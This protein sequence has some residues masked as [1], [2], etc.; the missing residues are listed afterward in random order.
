[1]KYV[2]VLVIV[3]VAVWVMMGRSRGRGRDSKPDG[4]G[5]DDPP[6]AAG[7]AKAAGTNGSAATQTMVGCTHCGLHLPRSEAVADAQ[8]R[9][10]CGDV[11]RLAGPR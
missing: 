8:G 5:R 3:I 9:L 10:Y 2:L 6:T 7:G 11:H 4:A 1:M